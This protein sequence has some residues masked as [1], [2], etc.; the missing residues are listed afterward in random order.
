MS[1]FGGQVGWVA[2]GKRV[3]RAL[4]L[5]FVA[6]KIASKLLWCPFQSTTLNVLR[7]FGDFHVHR[8]AKPFAG[9]N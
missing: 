7:T 6:I 2:P 9:I 5:R 8:N 4:T 3:V 1:A